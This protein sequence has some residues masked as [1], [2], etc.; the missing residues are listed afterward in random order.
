M[1]FLKWAYQPPVVVVPGITATGLED[2]YPMPPEPVWSAVL[3]KDYDR[4]A[5]HPDDVRYEAREPALVRAVQPFGVV[6]EDLVDALRYDLTA[7][8]DRPT[9]V[10]LFGYDW[11]Q[12]CRATAVQLEAFIDETLERTRLLPHYRTR[13]GAP[14]DGMRVDLVAHSMGGLV[15]ADCLARLAKTA[16]GK[17]KVRRV[18]TMATPFQGSVDAVEKLSTGLGS[19]SGT[20]PHSRERES[21]RTIP[22]V[23]QLLP[24][25]PGAVRPEPGM[26]GNLLALDT[27]Q[28]SVLATLSTYIRRHKARIGARDLLARYLA[29]VRAL[30]SAANSLDLD[31]VLPEGR[32]GWMPIAGVGA[33]TRPYTGIVNYKNNP[34]FA[35]ADRTDR[36]SGDRAS[37]ETGDGTVPFDGAAPYPSV[38]ETERLVCVS[39]GEFGFLEVRDR[40]LARAA[41]F[42]ASLPNM[43]LVQRLAI[44]FLKPE[45]DT[46]LQ[47]WPAPGVATPLWPKELRIANL[48][49]G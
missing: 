42:H 1:P 13:D 24:T 17:R 45:F 11:R 49:G 4:L 48:E 7:R 6:Y 20:T 30:R 39:P 32:D 27:W 34:W 41:G 25:Y 19:F 36:W 16:A 21:A 3:T 28:P 35:V 43:N 37:R 10:F 40:V 2:Y 15:V 38:L 22:A 12:D 29:G 46:D 14:L 44:R 26:P 33:E 31:K 23:Y 47:A 5:M 9:P 8:A 18:V